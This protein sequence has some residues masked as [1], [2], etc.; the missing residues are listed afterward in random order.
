MQP[1]FNTTRGKRA[2]NLLEHRRFRAAYDFMM[3]RAE[4]GEIEIDTA[5]F[6]TNVQKQNADQ[7]LES[8]GISKQAKTGKRGRRPRRRRGKKSEQ[9]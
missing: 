1:R 6:W 2:F 9:Q 4:G 7:R 5:H 3:L 8:F